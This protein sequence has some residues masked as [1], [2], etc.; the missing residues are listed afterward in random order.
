MKERKTGLVLEGGAMRGMYTA[1]VLDVLMEEQIQ[2]DGA[3]GV[4]AGAVFGCNYKSG[5][6]GRAI[7]YNLR[8]CGDKRYGTLRSLLRTG[9][10]YDE[11]LCYH[12]IPEKSDPFDLQAFR[13]NPMDFYVVCTDVRTGKAVY[14]LCKRG[15]GAD[16]KWM[17][18]SASMPLVSKVVSVDGYELLDGGI[19][20]SIPVMWFRSQGYRRNLV[21]LT[22]PEGYRK[23]KSRFSRSLGVLMHR[24][25][26]LAEAMEQRYLNYNHSLAEL[27][28]LE[29]KGEALVLRPSRSIEVSR[30]EKDAGKL[31]ALYQLGRE[32]AFGQRD[33]IKSFLSKAFD[34]NIIG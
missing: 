9:N 14:H 19:A 32:D 17:Q 13:S 7:R 28:V 5:Q 34:P 1:G 22:R 31:K 23:K 15:D 11:E 6:A 4:S 26:Q 20:D 29:E 8:Y 25:P 30:L 2:V 27:K 12:E 21:I 3:I 18:A 16:M 24:Y 33:R 10:I